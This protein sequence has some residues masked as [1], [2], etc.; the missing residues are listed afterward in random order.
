[1]DYK[2]A[3][4][5][6]AALSVTLIKRLVTNG[7]WSNQTFNTLILYL[8]ERSLAV[9][10]GKVAE[11]YEYQAITHLMVDYLKSNPQPDTTPELALRLSADMFG[12]MDNQ[13]RMSIEAYQDVSVILRDTFSKMRE[14]SKRL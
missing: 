4:A 6:A 3:R 14:L 12:L 10:A 7:A 9:Q 8:E 1:M 2:D 13:S 5:Q 11:A